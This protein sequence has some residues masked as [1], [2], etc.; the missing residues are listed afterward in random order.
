MGPLRVVDQ[1]GTFFITARKIEMLLTVLLICADRVVSSDQLIYE[2][3]G[4]RPPRRATAGLHVYVSQIRKLLNRDGRSEGRVLTQAPGYILR[5]DGDELDFSRFQEL[6][7]RG[8]EYARED[9]HGP[10]ASCFKAAHDLWRG[11][12]PDDEFRGPIL[13]GFQ[14]WLAEARLECLE[15][16][17][18]SRLGLGQH[19]ELVS[20]LYRLTT[21]NPLTEPFHRQLMLALYRSGRQADALQ[22]YHVAR[23]TLNNELGLDP[24][25]SLQGLHRAILAA[26]DELELRPL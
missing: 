25:R 4:D 24:G 17:M 8:R 10:A 19:R 3:W 1:E 13:D 5:L 9:D 6:V 21:E 2:L 12:T 23:R 7:A 26:D 11:L 20:D 18:E 16:L 15:L 22:A 14:T